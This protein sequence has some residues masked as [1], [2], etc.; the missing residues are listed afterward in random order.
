MWNP[1]PGYSQKLYATSPN[2]WHAIANMPAGNTAVV[3]YPNVGQQYY[4]SNTLGQISSMYSSFAENMNPTGGTSAEAAYDIWL[5]DW[6]NEVMIQH[7]LVGRE[8][9]PALAHASFG[10]S[11]G[12]PVQEWNLCD[13]G[14]EL[15]WQ[16]DGPGEHSGSVDVLAML[17]WLTGHGYLPKQ[18]GLT[19][20]SYGF[21]IC[22]T[23]GR[24][25]TF[26]VSR[27][28]LSA[29]S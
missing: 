2:S 4:Y 16:L 20:I 18:T 6:H 5:N 7:D 27:F 22:S 19:A 23:G 13:Y 17:T 28:T 14:S 24:P 1:I 15:I 29:E 10:G 25:E 3:S 11:G 21:E 12:V 9:C 8:R 26:E